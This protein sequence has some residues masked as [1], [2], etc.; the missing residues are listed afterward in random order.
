MQTML[1]ATASKPLAAALQ[2]ALP[3]YR[4]AVCHTG[5]QALVLLDELR[6]DKLVI[7]LCLP[8]LSGL[9]VLTQAQQKPS[10]IMAL[11]NLATDPITQQAA[12]LGVRDMVRLPC[13]VSVIARRLAQMQ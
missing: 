4:I 11:T 12:A 6:P 7:E 13:K 1:I 8:G 2:A 10:Y 9:T 5:Q 3:Q